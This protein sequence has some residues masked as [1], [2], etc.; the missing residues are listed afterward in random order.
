MVLQKKKKK[1]T[2]IPLIHELHV[3]HGPLSSFGL[4]ILRAYL[5]TQIA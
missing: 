3:Q 4:V 2:P 5:I 1:N